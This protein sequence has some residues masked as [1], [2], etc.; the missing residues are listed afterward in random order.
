MSHFCWVRKKSPKL[1][2]L[3]RTV[4][5][6]APE[7]LSRMSVYLFDMAGE[8]IAFRQT[9]TDPHLFDLGGH[10]IGWFPWDDHD[11]VDCDG[12]YLGTVVDDR[13]VRRND[14]YVR[15]CSTLDV[16]PGDTA[17]TGL[18][19]T[20]HEFPNRFAYEDVGIQLMT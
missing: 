12:Q 8:A 10:W 1:Q 4:E 9:W 5:A 17:P 19:Q 14:W 6:E 3:S 20:P 7:G 13:L 11:A 18:P 15:P 16:P 2:A